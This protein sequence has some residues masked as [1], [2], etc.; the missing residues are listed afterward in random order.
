MSIFSRLGHP[1]SKS[2][3]V[4]EA[5]KRA[6]TSVIPHDVSGSRSPADLGMEITLPGATGGLGGGAGHPSAPNPYSLPNTP[7]P[8]FGDPSMGVEY[9]AIP[10]NGDMMRQIDAM[11][12]PSTQAPPG[13][14]AGPGYYGP[15]P[16]SGNNVMI[17][18]MSDVN[19]ANSMALSTGQMGHSV[20]EP[21]PTPPPGP[22]PGY[23]GQTPM[24]GSNR[25]RLPVQLV[26]THRQWQY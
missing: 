15:D 14:G 2:N 21:G 16:M 7:P 26:P 12:D 22:G 1:S 9:G 3:T 8:G 24:S 25:D 18:N 4:A 19:T 6:R 17:P 20:Y 13:P 10:N 23:Y 5:T 11:M